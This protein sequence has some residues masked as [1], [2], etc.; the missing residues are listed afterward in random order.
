MCT[1][2]ANEEMHKLS[3]ITFVLRPDRV[4]VHCDELVCLSVCVSLCL[5]LTAII[6]SELHVLSSWKFLWLLIMAVARSSSGSVVICYVI[7]VLWMTSYLLTSQGC[8]TSSPS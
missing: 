5:C 4:A 7:P 1:T 6:S 3:E 2:V 8:L